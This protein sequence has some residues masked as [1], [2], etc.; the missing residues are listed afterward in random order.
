MT[1]TMG[2]ASLNP[3]YVDPGM[4]G[5]SRVVETA[6]ADTMLLALPNRHLRRSRFG[7]SDCLVRR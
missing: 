2:I 6:R 1:R 7:D 4:W 5:D 3:S